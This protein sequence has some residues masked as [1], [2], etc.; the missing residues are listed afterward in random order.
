MKINIQ[1]TKQTATY[2]V[3][4]GQGTMSTINAVVEKMQPSAAFVITDSHVAPLYLATLIQKLDRLKLPV[5]WYVFPAG[6]INKNLSTVQKIYLELVKKVVDRSGLIINLGGGVTTD[7]GGFTAATYLRS[8]PYIN[9]PTSFEAMVDAAIG[10]KVG[11]D[12][13]DLKNY[14]GLFYHPQA[15][16]IDIDTLQTLSKRAFL[17]GFA[18]V[19]KHGLILD[20]P[21]FQL[22]TSKKPLDF[23]PR[24]LEK[25]VSGSIRLKAAIIKTDPQETKGKRKLLNFGHTI[26]HAVESLSLQ[27]RKPLFHGEAVAVGMVAEAKISELLGMID[28]QEF[29]IIEKSINKAD[30]P[31]RA[32]NDSKRAIWQLIKTDK[33]NSGGKI[34]WTLLQRIGKAVYNQPVAD[35]LVNK[36]I[37]FI[38]G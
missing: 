23:T 3:I 21:Y 12:F 37:D 15:V 4:I 6:E 36:A 22:V 17:Q 9:I 5:H 1:I 19:I 38:K 32:N 13:N 11:V 34:N 31:I 14:V 16:I 8:I 29:Q 28:N 7:L 18:E 30:L 33:K 10:G 24:Q 25:I 20:R 2:P 27:T 26:G 35:Q